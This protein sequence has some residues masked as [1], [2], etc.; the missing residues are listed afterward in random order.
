[1]LEIGKIE[2][3]LRTK[4]IDFNAVLNTIVFEQILPFL[5]LVDN[6][7]KFRSG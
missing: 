2:N 4:N 5:I 1:M 7:G 6:K 3:M